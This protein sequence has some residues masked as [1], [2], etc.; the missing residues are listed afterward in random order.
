MILFVMVA[1]LHQEV[2]AGAANKTIPDKGVHF[3]TAAD[4]T[5]QQPRHPVGGDVSDRRS[6]YESGVE[7]GL[8]GV[9]HSGVVTRFGESQRFD[10]P[11]NRVRTLDCF[12]TRSIDTGSGFRVFGV[13][14]LGFRVRGLG[15]DTPKSYYD[16]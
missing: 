8:G 13:W 4:H 10:T 12:D 16:A 6:K 11:P 15:S 1:E 5:F 14:F 2:C 7:N 3:R 9:K